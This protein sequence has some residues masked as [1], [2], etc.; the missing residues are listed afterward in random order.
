VAGTKGR[1]GRRNIA[2]TPDDFDL[3]PL[4]DDILSVRTH[5]EALSK[6]VRTGVIDPRV[7]DSLHK[8]AAAHLRALVA[9]TD[10]KEITEVIKR[11][12]KRLDAID[13]AANAEAIATRQH[14]RT[15]DDE[16]AAEYDDPVE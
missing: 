1:S 5:L 14:A 2:Q 13:L 4:G 8:I 9:E 3:P 16:P 6:A 12:A 10:K 15:G 7:G 11:L